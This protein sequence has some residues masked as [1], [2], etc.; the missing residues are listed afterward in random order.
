MSIDKDDKKVLAALLIDARQSVAAIA[1]ITGLSRE[2]VSYRMQ[3]LEDA[4]IIRAYVARIAQPRFCAGVA[5]V[6]WKVSRQQDDAFEHGIR[7]AVMHK[8]VN[9]VGELCGTYDLLCT[10]MYEHADDLA[11]IVSEL[12]QQFGTQLRSHEVILYID[13]FKF[14]RSGLLDGKILERGKSL[15]FDNSQRVSLDKLDT[16]I[17][18]MLLRDC[19]LSNTAIAAQANVSE[20]S[21][22]LRI[23]KLL[24][25]TANID[26]S[27]LGYELYLLRLSL[28]PFNDALASKISYYAK[29]NP[30]IIHAARTSGHF[31]VVLSLCVRDR[32]HF[33]EQLLQLR[34][35]FGANLHDYEFHLELAEHKEVFLAE[36]LLQ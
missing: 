3:Q 11:R 23:K 29:I 24:G 6:L 33:S 1:R 19:R 13:E 17:V 10:V 21:V 31:N 36:G 27:K 7:S 16:Q 25:Y 18:K 2:V 20:D 4:G 22:R 28:E 30:W 26:A 9:W 5:C 14:D 15:V 32:T 8:K 12:A 34:K 35:E